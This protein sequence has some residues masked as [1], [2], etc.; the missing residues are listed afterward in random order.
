MFKPIAL[1]SCLIAALSVATGCGFQPEEPPA[2]EGE[3]RFISGSAIKTL[4]PQATSWLI[5]FRII[6]GLFEPLLRVN[7][8]TMEIEP[9]AAEALPQ[10][11][12]DGTVYTFTIREDAKWSNGDPLLASDYAYGWQRAL[13]F[14]LAADYSALFFCIEGAEDFFNWRGEQLRNFKDAGVSAD[15][16]WAQTLARFDETVGI[17]AVDERTLEVTL[18]QPTAYFNELVAFAPFSPVHRASADAYL[19]PDADSGTVT[20]DPVYFQKPELIVSNGPYVLSTWQ[21]KQRLVL[22]QNPNWWNREAMGNTRVVVQVNT[23]P[24]NGLL[25]YGE[26]ETDWYPSFPTASQDAAKLVASGRDDVHYGAAAGTYFYTFNCEPNYG[27]KPNLFADARVR[28]AF[29]LAVDRKTLVENVTQ[30]NQPVALTFIPPD[31]L[32]NYT[33]P[34]D[35]GVSFDA[36]A[37]KALLAEAGYPN[38]EGLSGITLLINE[39]GGHEDPAQAIRKGWETHLGVTVQIESVERTTFSDRL[40]NQG[41]QIAR[42]GWFGDYRD[43]TTF[44]DKFH[45]RNNNNDA[46]YANAAYDQLL[47]AAET[48]MDAPARLK[49]LAEA[50]ALMLAEQPLMPLY[51]YT[52]LELFDPAR[53]KNH[54]PNPWNVRRLDAIEVLPAE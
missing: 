12:D 23:D 19:K 43:P 24:G 6:E 27:G 37:A 50:E 9:S 28:R 22:D 45:S 11:K 38:G 32:P 13:L 26:G 5:D 39:G 54:H 49:M 53:V 35:A 3:L 14:D 29:S 15:D 17:K 8:A 1:C 48:E 52:N 36:A 7:P 10:V 25:R 31:A 34:T 30:L 40:K 33:A 47:D 2:A 18:K 44:L 20:M 21:F 41:F 46:K 4:D 16:L 51:H 42:A